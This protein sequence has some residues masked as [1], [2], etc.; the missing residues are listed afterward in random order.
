VAEHFAANTP[1]RESFD[2]DAANVAVGQSKANALQCASCHLPGYAGKDSVPRMAG[3]HPQYAAGQI[4]SFAA[5]S[6]LHPRIDGRSG[7]SQDDAEALGQ[8]FAQVR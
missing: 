4:R 1:V 2:V 8:Y 7:I 5:G 3:L 6:R